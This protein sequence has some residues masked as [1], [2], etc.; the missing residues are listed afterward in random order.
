MDQISTYLP[1]DIYDQFTGAL[2]ASSTAS[3]V[4]DQYINQFRQAYKNLTGT[5]PGV[6]DIQNFVQQAGVSS[7]GLPGDLSFQD[8]SSLANNYVQ[9]TYPN[10]VSQYSQQQQTD[11]L[12]KTSGLINN[13][14]SSVTGNAAKLF[15]DP[16]SDVYRSFS[17]AMNNMGITPSSGAFQAGA[18]GALAGTA[19]DAIN[20]ALE[21]VGI[22][23][24]GG[25]QG[26][27]NM[28]FQ[29]A[30][31]Q[32]GLGHLNELGDFGLKAAYDQLA[33]RDAAPSGLDKGLGYGASFLGAAGSAGQGIGAASQ[34]TSYI[35]KE[36]IARGLIFEQDMHDFHAHIMPAMF[37]KGRAFWKYAMD[38]GWLAFA[39]NRR[40]DSAEIWKTFKPDLFDRVMT[41]LDPCKAVDLYS[42]ACMRLCQIAA[43]DL[44]DEKVYRTSFLD[45]LL[46]LPRLLTYRPFLEALRKAIRVKLAF[47]PIGVNHGA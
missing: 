41:E 4:G 13:L 5:D 3:G 45:S 11:Q 17:G 31:N 40:E 2:G 46:F 47:L 33:A 12:G 25:I 37:Q 30:G 21:T 36:L 26:Q 22:P 8:L 1:Q 15:S 16:K 27:S 6:Q 35:C 14:V 10:Q 34:V 20:K 43:P 18:G 29:M 9:Q 19:N 32:N 42:E 44:W 7:A 28:P 24:I 23:A 39:I 38:A